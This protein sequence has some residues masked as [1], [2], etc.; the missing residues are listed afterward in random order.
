M[1]MRALLSL[2]VLGGLGCLVLFTA[3]EFRGMPQWGFLVTTPLLA[4]HLRQVLNNREPAALDPEL[5]R[6]S[7][8]TFFTAIAFAAGLILA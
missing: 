1:A 2:L 6:L 4:T 3:V 8:G 5:K 7:L